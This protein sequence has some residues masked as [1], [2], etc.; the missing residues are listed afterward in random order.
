MPRLIRSQPLIPTQESASGVWSLDDAFN[1]VKTKTWPIA[2]QVVRSLRFND[3]ESPYLS[4][5]PAGAGNRKT[6]TWSAWIKI[7]DAGTYLGLLSVGTT[8]GNEDTVF[9]FNNTL[10]IRFDTGS[11]NTPAPLLRDSS[12]WYH[13][14]LS[15]DT[16]QAIAKNRLK[17]YVNGEYWDLDVVGYNSDH[18][19]FPSLNHDFR[20]NNNQEHFLGEFPRINAHWDGYM[21][22]INFIDGQ[23]LTADSFGE[24]RDGVWSPIDTAGL[25]FGTNGFYLKFND[26]TDLG[27]DVSGNGNDFTANNLFA[28]DVVLDSPKDNFATL[29]PIFP[30]GHTLSQGN[31]QATY[32]AAWNTTLGTIAPSSGKWYFEA[33]LSSKSWQMFGVDQPTIDGTTKHVGATDGS[34]GIGFVFD[35]SDT[36]GDIS[37][38][39]SNSVYDNGNLGINVGDTVGIAMDLDNNNVKFY[40]NN[41]LQYDLSNLLEDGANY[42]FGLSLYNSTAIANFGQ[43]P[44][45]YTPPQGYLPLS[46]DALPA[47]VTPSDYFN[48]VLYTGNNGTQSISTVGFDPSFVWIKARN[49]SAMGHILTDEVRGTG[50]ALISNATNAEDTNHEFG[51][52]SS[53]DS[54]GFTVT[55]GS[56]NADRVN[57]SSYNY[58]AWCW[59][60]G[61]APVSNT[62]GSITS[63]VSAN[64]DAGFSIVSYTGTGSDGSVG[65]G[66]SQTPEFFILKN[67]DD[68]SDWYTYTTIVD[69]S[70]DYF[71][72]NT[73]AAKGDSGLTAPTSSLIYVGGSQAGNST[74][75]EDQIIYAF[76]SVEGF[77]KFG[78]YTG[79]GS[80]DGPFVYTGFR[81]AFI[82]V[83]R[84]DS[85][86]EW[87][88]HDNKRDPDNVIST[89]L[90]AHGSD[91]EVGSLALYDFTSNG[92][93]I[94][95]S[96]S[97]RNASGGTYIYMAFAETPLK[98]T[99]AR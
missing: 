9:L 15:V 79:N 96:N 3:N 11:D 51:Y 30:N 4:R 5:T 77:S 8:D 75:G 83:K 95:S 70:M 65:H 74:S 23:A 25:T 98:T 57:N 40:L 89:V 32:D 14:V 68:T 56:T 55:A 78:S 93:K 58:V 43:R 59:K 17:W 28:N 61:G 46:T 35:P 20:I 29:N 90:F 10:R 76:H 27:K 18:N 81:P 2:G 91:A 63:Q 48:T 6:W 39:S 19:N 66:L 52:L 38:N 73:T 99:R 26:T 82:L 24:L 80:T 21:A 97:N 69:G 16:T 34:K 22:E 42:T 53:F 62:D 50:K 85:T 92:F 44:F 13:I 41:E 47:T 60:A 1:A 94:R 12:A 33:V 84:T 36:R 31:L 86:S 67:R 54:N 72:L 71:F 64:T 88:I 49:T 7:G 87:G 45:T 37:Y